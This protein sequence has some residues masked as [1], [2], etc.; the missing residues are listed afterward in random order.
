[1]GY[2]GK[3]V[4]LCYRDYRTGGDQTQTLP[5]V[6][7]LL[8]LL[9]HVWPRYQRDVFSFGLYQPSRR[10]AHTEAVVA[11][12]RFGEQVRPR[13]ALC[14]WQRLWRRLSEPTFCC[15]LCGGALFLEQV[16]LGR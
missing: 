13:R 6:S 9:Q 12:S 16:G 5:A 4:T 14:Q 15:P 11:A 2:D 7:F 10:K 8:R 1:M 3:Q